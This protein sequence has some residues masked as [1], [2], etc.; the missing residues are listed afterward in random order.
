MSQE[1]A[2]PVRRFYGALS[3]MPSAYDAAGGRIEDAPFIDDVFALADDD[4]QWR[5]LLSPDTFRGRQGLLR[6]AAE[7][8]EVVGRW[9]I[10]L[11]DVLDAGDH[12]LATHVVRA[13]G[14]GSGALSDQ[15]VYTVVTLRDRRILRLEDHLDRGTALEAAGLA[16]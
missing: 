4:I 8:L 3:R 11:E 5:W 1:D 6:A 13:Q 12:V 7:W 14:R 16:E 15:R 9:Q 2:E 10:D